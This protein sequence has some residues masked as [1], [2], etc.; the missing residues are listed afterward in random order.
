MTNSRQ[1]DRH[2]LPLQLFQPLGNHVF[3]E[4]S[5]CHAQRFGNCCE[6]R[7]AILR[8][9]DVLLFDAPDGF[10]LFRRFDGIRLNNLG[11]RIRLRNCRIFGHR[12]WL[13]LEH[14]QHGYSSP[15]FSM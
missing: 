12:L 7:A 5:F 6:R 11:W 15:Y 13:T 10:R 2:P 14:G 8:N 3:E 1:F 9:L 4:L